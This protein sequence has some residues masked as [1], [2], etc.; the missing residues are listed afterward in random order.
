MRSGLK[1]FIASVDGATAIEYG[2]VA[3]L[4]TVAIVGT[5]AAI[6]VDL[7]ALFSGV[8]TELQDAIPAPAETP[9]PPPE[10][11]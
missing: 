8:S 10:P 3:A 9:E 1:R 5:L 4:I 11:L 7:T 6:G 2:I